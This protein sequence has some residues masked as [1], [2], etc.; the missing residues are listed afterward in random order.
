[1]EKKIFFRINPTPLNE[2]KYISDLDFEE[3]LARQE[4]FLYKKNRKVHLQKFSFFKKKIKSIFL[5]REAS[6]KKFDFTP[7][8]GRSPKLRV[9]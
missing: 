8:V 3:F 4:Q 9:F 6:T 2:E 7:E 5:K 1:M